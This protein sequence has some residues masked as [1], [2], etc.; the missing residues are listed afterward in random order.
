M[1]YKVVYAKAT[2]LHDAIEK[3]EYF[4]V[5]NNTWYELTGEFGGA[6]GF[7]MTNASSKFR[8]TFKTAG[9]YSFTANMKSAVD[10]SVLC[11][12][13]VSFTVNPAPQQDNTQDTTDNTTPDNTQGTT[14]DTNTQN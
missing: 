4:E 11:E 3:L 2:Y 9:T 10:G 7:P 6:N 13:N 14:Q 5:S 1:Q 8:V 12:T